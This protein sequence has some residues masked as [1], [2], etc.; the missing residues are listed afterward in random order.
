MKNMKA[1][2]NGSNKSGRVF[3]DLD[4]QLGA[5]M[6]SGRFEFKAVIDDRIIYRNKA[7]NNNK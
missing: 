5:S 1:K 2:K 4:V 6:N 3:E 7:K